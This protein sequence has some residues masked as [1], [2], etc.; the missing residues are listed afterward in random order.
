MTDEQGYATIEFQL[1]Q[2]ESQ[3]RV[4]ID[5]FGQGRIGSVELPIVCQQKE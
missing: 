4:L 1:P 3:Y 2:V 5:A